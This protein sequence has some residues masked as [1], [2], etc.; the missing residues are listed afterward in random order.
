MSASINA[1]SRWGPELAVSVSPSSYE[2]ARYFFSALRTWGRSVEAPRW[3]QLWAKLDFFRFLLWAVWLLAVF[4]MYSAH[5]EA[6]AKSYY[7]DQAYKILRDGV[8]T[9]NQQKATETILALESE[10]AAPVP[11]QPLGRQFWFFALGGLITCIILTFPPGVEIGLGRG[12]AR[13][14]NWQRW[15]KFVFVIVPGFIASNFIWP[16]VADAIR[17]SF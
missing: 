8:N 6:T 15:L 7:R 5:N 17:R 1:N 14:A 3:Q 4:A 13:I 12:E 16:L 9:G 2:P 10:Y 11:A